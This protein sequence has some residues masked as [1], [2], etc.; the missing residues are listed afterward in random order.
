MEVPH[1]GKAEARRCWPGFGV[2]PPGTATAS[3]AGP[4]APRASKDFGALRQ[5]S[6][7]AGYRGERVTMLAGTDVPRINAVCEVTAMLMRRLGINLDYVATD[8]GTMNQRLPN[9]RAPAEGGWNCYCVYSSGFDQ[10]SPVAYVALRANNVRAGIGWPDIPALE[11]LRE[12]RFNAPDLA[13][14]RA[15]SRQIQAMAL[16][17]AVF[18]PLGQFVQP[19]AYRRVLTDMPNGPP[20]FTG[21]R[22]RA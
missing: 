4:E 7:E 8:W 17:L 3:D 1:H 14:Q 5:A 20:L 12:A 2:F 13:G 10:I 21:V 11:R 19:V 6:Q 22:K 15:I 18:V 9:R 16:D